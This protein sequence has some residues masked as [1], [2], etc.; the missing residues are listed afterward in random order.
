MATAESPNSAEALESIGAARELIRSALAVA[1][2]M[3]AIDEEFDVPGESV[4]GVGGVLREMLKAAEAR[5]ATAETLIHDETASA[6]EA[7]RSA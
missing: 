2:M 6:D 5:L 4:A 1:S 3:L 7:Q